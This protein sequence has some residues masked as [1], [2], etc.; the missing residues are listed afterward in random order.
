MSYLGTAKIGLHTMWNEHFGIGVVE[1]MAAG[2]IPVA[3]KSGGPKFDIVTEYDGKPTGYLA[4]TADT[5]ADSLNS[6]LALTEVEYEQMA[7][8]AR[9]SASDKFSE[10]AFSSDLLCCLRPCLT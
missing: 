7:T 2:L 9:A 8:N 3:H 1:Y 5:F 6:A 4:N 10:E